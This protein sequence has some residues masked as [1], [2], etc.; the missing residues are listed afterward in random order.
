MEAPWK[1]PCPAACASQRRQPSLLAMTHMR[2]LHCQSGHESSEHTR[3]VVP[4]V[5]GLRAWPID[6]C[7]DKDSG[8]HER[9]TPIPCVET[10]GHKAEAKTKTTTEQHTTTN[11]AI[12][13]H[14]TGQGRS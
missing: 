2:W 10:N 4:Y 14:S 9:K 1:Y 6:K 11:A 5:G 8:K 13:T 3:G 12:T 7:S